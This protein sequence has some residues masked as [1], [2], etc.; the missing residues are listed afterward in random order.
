L[1]CFAA[2]LLFLCGCGYI[3][4]PLPPLMNIPG[5]GDNVA[6]VQRGIEHHCARHFAH[7]DHR[8]VVLIKQSVR[9][10]LRIGPK[11]DGSFNA[12][13]WAA[14]AKAVG[15]GTIANGIAE[16]RIPATEWI[17]K[18]VS[19]AVKM[20][21]ANGRDAGWSAPAELTVVAPPEQ[22]R[23]L[24][25]EAVPQGVRLT[26]HGSGSAFAVLRRGPDEPDYRALGRSP[27]PEYID[28][29]AEFGKPYRYLV[30][31]MVKVGEGEAQSE[32]SSE[33]A[34][35]PVDTFPPA[36]PAGL[37]AVPSTASVELV[38]ERSTEP[39]SLDI[40]SIARP[41]ARPS[42][43]WPTRNCCPPTAIAR[44]NRAKP[45]A[46]PSAQSRATRRRASCRKRWKLRRRK[47]LADWPFLRNTAQKRSGCRL[48][49]RD[50]QARGRSRFR[51]VPDADLNI[52]PKQQQKPHQPFN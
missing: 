48:S 20:I 6:A 19:I 24:S 26:W 52:S 40:A 46:T 5:R 27:K 29:T 10:D 41:A 49:L 25:A 45:T 43:C 47:G 35:T 17:G 4:E 12:V 36:A 23:D 38:W 3:G 16:Y 9:L 44:S 21:G 30:Q 2:P 34:I 18:Q 22:P 13:A 37:T 28:A 1:V 32:L 33:A 50:P 42:N 7:F 8:R 14:G 11:P 31:S 51:F 39:R 15:G